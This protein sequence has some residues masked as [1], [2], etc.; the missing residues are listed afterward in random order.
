MVVHRKLRDS[1]SLL[2]WWYSVNITCRNDGQSY[3]YETRSYNLQKIVTMSHLG[4]TKV[5]EKKFILS[6]VYE[7]KLIQISK[8]LVSNIK[9]IVNIVERIVHIIL[10]GL[11][12]YCFFL[13]TSLFLFLSI[14]TSLSIFRF[15]QRD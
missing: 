2:L 9:R 4:L 15:C 12:V 11:P 3:K 14:S 13:S 8:G 5:Q 6:T 1:A 10:V 7:L